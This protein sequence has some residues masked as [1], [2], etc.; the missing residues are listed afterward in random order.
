MLF[1]VWEMRRAL[2][3]H[4]GFCRRA[5][6]DARDVCRNVQEQYEGAHV[7]LLLNWEMCRT[8]VRHGGVCRRAAGDAHDFRQR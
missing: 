4:G 7:I 3:Q 8:P 6:G 5:A 1:L 2:D